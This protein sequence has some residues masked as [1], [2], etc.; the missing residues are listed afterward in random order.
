MGATRSIRIN[1]DL[2]E[3]SA[4]RADPASQTVEA[5]P[6]V[7]TDVGPGSARAADSFGFLIQFGYDFNRDPARFPP[8]PRQRGRHAPPPRGPRQEGGDRRPHRRSRLGA[9]QPGPLRAP[10]RR[11][12]LVPDPR[13][14]RQPL[15]DRD[16][17]RRRA[18]PAAPTA[19]PTT[20]RTAASNSAPA[21]HP[22]R[23][24]RTWLSG[25]PVKLIAAAGAATVARPRASRGPLRITTPRRQIQA[26]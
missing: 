6:T 12:P 8:L 2:A 20:P 5:D 22:H 15:P 24:C 10:R 26:A 19:T 9:V 25:D 1:P 23:G 4:P 18:R 3:P 7:A 16:R 21:E 17:G 11:R 14:R 13:V